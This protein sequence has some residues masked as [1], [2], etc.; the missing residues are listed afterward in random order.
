M[1]KIAFFIGSMNRGG[2]ERV[3][4][5]L[6]KSYAERGYKT[7][8][9]MLLSNEVGYELHPNTKVLDFTGNTSS[10]LKRLPYWIKSIRRYVKE[11]KPDVIVSFVARINVIVYLATLG[12][13]TR[14]I[15]S[16]RNDPRYDG[17]S[18]VT[19]V[20]TKLIY[21]HVESVVFQTERARRYFKS[22]KNCVIIPNP[23]QV[24]REATEEKTG[25]IV[26]VGRLAPQKNQKLLIFALS[27]VA[28]KHPD[29]H[30]EIY[31]EGV[32]RGE[33]T[34]YVSELGL[35]D[36]VFLKGNVTDVH[37]RIS[38]ASVFCLSSDYEGLSNALLEAMMVGLPCLSTN[39]AGADECISDG[40]NGFLVD[41]GDGDSLATRLDT[42]LSDEQLRRSFAKKAKETS[43]QFTIDR[44]MLEWDKLI[45]GENHD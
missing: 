18:V 43:K 13:K 25:K 27:K 17:R 19:D 2:A 3:I 42:L 29:A 39:C 24:T 37:D 45:N 26:T 15:V 5:I 21:P 11:E 7:D 41:I 10:R 4:S 28:A 30:L 1:K 34:S 38:D 20:A 44:V 31:G 8:I 9:V 16:E 23:I 14:L 33:L 36:R 35:N 12:L 6:S 32:M 40:K 22:V